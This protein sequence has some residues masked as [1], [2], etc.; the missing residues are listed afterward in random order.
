[1]N[2][3]EDAESNEETNHDR[4]EGSKVAAPVS[5]PGMVAEAESGEER[6]HTRKQKKRG[7]GR[8][9]AVQYRVC[10]DRRP[11]PPPPSQSQKDNLLV[12]VAHR[13]QL[14]DD[15]AEL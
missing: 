5:Q 14:T 6:T 11:V 13:C 12:G 1:M 15:E 8:L 2:E 3:T 7:R 9:D 10:N 4:G